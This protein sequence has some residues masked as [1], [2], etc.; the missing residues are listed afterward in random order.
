M[1][2]EVTA[3]EVTEALEL[4]RERLEKEERDKAEKEERERKGVKTMKIP[5]GVDE[6]WLPAG[7][8]TVGGGKAQARRRKK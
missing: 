4:E 6:E 3:E 2:E 8:T 1:G 5:V 7:A